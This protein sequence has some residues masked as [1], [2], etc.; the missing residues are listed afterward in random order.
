[1]HGDL[2]EK[3]NALHCPRRKTKRRSKKSSNS[4][5]EP[6][7]FLTLSKVLLFSACVKSYPVRVLQGAIWIWADASPTAFIDCQVREPAIIPELED[8]LPPGW[9]RTTVN[10][11]ARDLPYGW[12]YTHENVMDRAHL[13]ISHHNITGHTFP[14]DGLLCP[15]LF[16]RKPLQRCLLYEY[17]RQSGK[18]VAR[19]IPIVAQDAPRRGNGCRCHIRPSLSLEVRTMTFHKGMS[20][21][22]MII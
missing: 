6:H 10:W 21:H 18:D 4:H 14:H 8:E 5:G 17:R 3:V 7:S 16:C 13:A 19:W 9:E 22:L 11:M 12:D 15:S 1:M 20:H 2:M